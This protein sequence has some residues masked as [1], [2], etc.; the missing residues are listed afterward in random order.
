MLSPILS[1]VALLM[2]SG[3]L[4]G[5]RNDSFLLQKALFTGVFVYGFKKCTFNGTKLSQSSVKCEHGTCSEHLLKI[6]SVSMV[7]IF[8][9]MNSGRLTNVLEEATGPVSIVKMEEPTTYKF[10]VLKDWMIYVYH[11]TWYHNQDDSTLI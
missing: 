4:Y 11:C 9:D 7:F 1:A 10:L 2:D 3:F 6:S 8:Q 5:L